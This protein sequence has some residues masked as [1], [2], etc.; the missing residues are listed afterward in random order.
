MKIPSSIENLIKENL[1]EEQAQLVLTELSESLK[2]EAITPPLLNEGRTEGDWNNLLPDLTDD[3]RPFD[4]LT[5]DII[6]QMLKSSPVRFSLEMKRSQ[7]VTVFRNERSWKIQSPDDELAD[8]ARA[9]LIQVLPKMALDFSFSSLVYGASFQELVWE[10]KTKFQLGLSDT[11]DS[12]KFVVAK[13]P[14]AVDPETVTKIKRTKDGHFDGFVQQTK[15]MEEILVARESALVIPYNEK[16]RNLW[17]ES[18]LKPMYPIWFW[19]EVVLRS[20]VRYMERIGTPVTVV[21]APSRSTIIRPGTKTKIDGITWGMEIAS[22]VSRSNAAVIPSDTDES[23]KP[24]WEIDYLS[25]SESSQPFLDILELLT[26]MILRAGLSAD[27]ALSQSSGGVGSYNIGEIHKEATA[28]HNEMILIQWVHYLNTYFLP[29]FSLYNK[30]KNGPPIILETEGLDPKDRE[31]LTSLLGVSANIESFKEASNKIDWETIFSTNNIPTISEEEAEALKKKMEAEGLAKQEE[32]MKMQSKFGMNPPG[33]KPVSK[34]GPPK[35]KVPGKPVNKFEDD[36]IIDDIPEIQLED[37]ED[38]TNEFFRTD[39]QKVALAAVET[40]IQL[41]N[42]YH[43][44]LGRFTTGPSRGASQSDGDRASSIASGKSALLSEGEYTEIYNNTTEAKRSML[45][46]PAEYLTRK[47]GMG[48]KIARLGLELGS[49]TAFSWTIATAAFTKGSVLGALATA[50]IVGALFGG[51]PTAATVIGGLVVG[52]AASAVATQLFRAGK[53]KLLHAYLERHAPK[54]DDHMSFIGNPS[55]GKWYNERSAM[56]KTFASEI[57]FDVAVKAFGPYVGVPGS[58]SVINNL[59]E[60]EEKDV[61]PNTDEFIG[62]MSKYTSAM[63]LGH[64]NSVRVP[65][66]EE[67]KDFPGFRKKGNSLVINNETLEEFALAYQNDTFPQVFIN[68]GDTSVEVRDE[69]ESS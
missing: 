39:R 48:P 6:N 54:D 38:D 20:M 58:W 57:G 36:I 5:F 28:L 46:A 47:E 31:N 17:G 40:A 59:M 63:V 9:N 33:N 30:G 4:T 16:F 50:A 1:Q 2:L 64:V 7:I 21:K 25:S 19:Y 61:E 32:Q 55:K 3:I 34:D 37:V 56:T 14:N 23:G 26:Q 22:N 35:P 52:A 15:K 42:P 29:H 43:D 13:I 12:K 44:S 65:Y 66:Q 62:I 53:E 11:E 67:L 68:F 8:I 45:A 24:L 49:E 41:F 27:R 18:F 60:L 51:A 10:Y 69:S